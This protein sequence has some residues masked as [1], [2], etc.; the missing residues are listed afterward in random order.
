MEFYKEKPSVLV[1]RNANG[2]RHSENQYE[3]SS[4]N[5]INL[6][7]HPAIAFLLIFPKNL[8]S[9]SPDICSKMF[10]PTEFTIP[11]KWKQPKCPSI[12]EEIM[13]VLQIDTVEHYSAVR[14]NET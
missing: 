2:G 1:G 14:E 5:W 6:S 8:T 7:Y 3:K 11:K 10:I 12:D 13:K 9:F 4:K